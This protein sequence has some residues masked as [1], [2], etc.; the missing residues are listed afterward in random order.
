MGNITIRVQSWDE[1]FLK[2]ETIVCKYLR[3][4]RWYIL[5]SHRRIAEEICM[6]LIVDGCICVNKDKKNLNERLEQLGQ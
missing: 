6:H 1:K 2:A 5:K 4:N 3:K